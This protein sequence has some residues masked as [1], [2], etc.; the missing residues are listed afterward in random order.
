MYR[1]RQTST[2]GIITYANTQKNNLVTE[3]KS[4][5]HRKFSI[6]RSAESVCF[7]LSVEKEKGF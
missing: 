5:R 6:Q 7:F 3:R 4:S 2:V 1:L